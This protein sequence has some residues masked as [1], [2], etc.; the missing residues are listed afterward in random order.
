MR[1]SVALVVGSA[2]R[3]VW[4]LGAVTLAFCL[5]SVLGWLR[6]AYGVIVGGTAGEWAS[7]LVTA[8]TRSSRRRLDA[9]V[10]EP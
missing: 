2:G 5:G 8:M 3:H 9:V 7:G 6:L 4:W 10:Q 1:H